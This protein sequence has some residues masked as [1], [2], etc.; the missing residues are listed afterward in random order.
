MDL[1]ENLEYNKPVL[2]VVLGNNEKKISLKT[3]VSTEFN[4]LIENIGGG[5][6]NGNIFCMDK[7]ISLNKTSFHGNKVNITCLLSIRDFVF[8]DTISTNITI[9]SNGGEKI[10]PVNVQVTREFLETRSGEK[11]FSIEN[12]KSYYEKNIMESKS[13]FYSKNFENFIK[14]INSN[15][16]TVYDF[17]IKD[18]NSN[19]AIENFFLMLD[20]KEQSKI[21]FLNKLV[22]VEISPFEEND[23]CGIIELKKIGNGYVS[24]NLSVSANWLTLKN[25]IITSEDFDEY[26]NY[27]LEYTIHKSYLKSNVNQCQ[28]FINENME[29]TIIVKVKKNYFAKIYLDKEVFNNKETAIIHIENLSSKSITFTIDS[30]NNILIDEKTVAVS[31]SIGIP[32]TIKL[33]P[34]ELGRAKILK[35]PY[36]ISKIK[37]MGTVEDIKFFK[38]LS[39]TIGTKSLE[40]A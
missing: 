12:F 28:I 4:F 10:I 39:V 33:T 37:V 29:N 36:F 22:E 27:Q 35:Q 26:N 5:S 30:S 16:K 15:Y 24:N 32:F 6:L 20:L 19:R 13:L 1:I 34:I 14:N 40:L 8:G 38:E 23:I 21:T 7:F 3:S 17:V 2:K 11:I 9:I 31:T 25:N 18:E